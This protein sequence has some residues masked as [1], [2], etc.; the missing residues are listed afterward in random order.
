MPDHSIQRASDLAG[1]ERLI[2]E[3][4]LGRAISN[5]E[6]ISI[7]AYRPHAGPDSLKQQRLRHDIVGQAREIGSRAGDVSDRELDEIL[8]E[9][10]DNARGLPG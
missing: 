3:R 6:T 4:W 10:F 5:E 1:D 9:A 8:G 7:N 2:V